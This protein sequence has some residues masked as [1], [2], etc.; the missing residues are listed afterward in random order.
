MNKGYAIHTLGCRTNRFESDALAQTLREMGFVEGGEGPAVVV[1]NTCTVTHRAD[2][3]SRQL[4]RKVRRENPGARLVVT[5]CL[6]QLEAERLREIQGVDLIL[7]HSLQS[8]LREALDEGLS[9]V[10][11]VGQEETFREFGS[12]AGTLGRGGRT[13]ALLKVQDGCDNACTYCRVRLA[14]GPSRSLPPEQALSA[15]SELARAG[16]KEIVLTG[17]H[18]GGYGADLDPP[19]SLSTLVRDLLALEGGPRLRLSSLDPAEVDSA[20]LEAVRAADRFCAHFHLPLQSG[21]ARVLARMGRPYSPA[22]YAAKVEEILA[23]LPGAAVGADVLVGFPGEDEK[24]HANTLALIRGLDLAYLH[25]F[26]FSPRPGTKAAGF[27][28]R[29]DPGLLK[30]RAQELRELGRRKKKAFLSQALGRPLEVLVE[31]KR[32]PKTGFLGGLSR[33][34]AAVLLDAPDHLVNHL[35]RV[36]GVEVRGGKILGEKIG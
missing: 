13:R 34:Y 19:T 17:I 31:A 27:G 6:A 4:I 3:Q 15:A 18:L 24:A 14:R 5:G 8:G 28:D 9:G 7:G 29:V 33:E 30:E 35:V 1:V 12:L 22:Q 26:P 11:G 21:D 36:R 16:H 23:L 2:Q 20:L 32:D 25:V 10:A